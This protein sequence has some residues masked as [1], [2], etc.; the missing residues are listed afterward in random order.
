[1]FHCESQ[2]PGPNTRAGFTAGGAAAEAAID[3][4]SAQ[5]AFGAALATSILE[6]FDHGVL[7]LGEHGRV[8]HANRVAL[9][10]CAVHGALR[11]VQ[12]RLCA[13][14]PADADRLTRALAGAARGLRTLLHFDGDER[15][16]PLVVMPLTTAP[17]MVE[18]SRTTGITLALLA[19][20]SGTEPLNIELFA[21]AHGLT[22]AERTVLRALARGLDP[23]ALAQAHGVAVST[24][25]TQIVRIRQKTR[26]ASIRELL[27]VINNLPPVVCTTELRC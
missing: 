17:T 22:M 8:L 3:D 23:A 18:G 11:L 14:R 20:R 16:L 12:G 10:E 15:C 19:K 21:Q 13:L 5:A 24:V 1:M 7:L 4:P 6:Q 27:D 26:T 25:R 2:A 9:R